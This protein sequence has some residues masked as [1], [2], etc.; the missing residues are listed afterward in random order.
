MPISQFYITIYSLIIIW[1]MYVFG[2]PLLILRF[3][4]QFI[5][6]VL[7]LLLNSYE[8]K[9][10]VSNGTQFLDPRLSLLFQFNTRTSQQ[11]L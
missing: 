7:Y 6:A 5:F 8:C 9:E 1:L 11:N 2:F 3:D 4:H 10:I